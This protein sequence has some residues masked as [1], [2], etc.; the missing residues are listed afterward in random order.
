MET[1]F[2]K[3]VFYRSLHQIQNKV[4]QSKTKKCHNWETSIRIMAKNPR[5]SKSTQTGVKWIVL[6]LIPGSMS[7]TPFHRNQQKIAPVEPQIF[8]ILLNWPVTT[9][10]IKIGQSSLRSHSD[11]SHFVKKVLHFVHGEHN[12]LKIF[13]IIIS[14]GVPIQ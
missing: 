12:Q 8:L 7:K 14:S 9:W 6:F 10:A 1:N 13:F 2:R 3:C 11:I 4:H 5:R